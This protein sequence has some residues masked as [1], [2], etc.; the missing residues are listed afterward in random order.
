MVKK[1]GVLVSVSAFAAVLIIIFTNL[2]PAQPD[3]KSS[4]NSSA[5]EN[6]WHNL[7]HE[8]EQF[9]HQAN[10]S[11]HDR[12]VEIKCF[13]KM[14]NH[15]AIEIIMFHFV[16][17]AENDTSQIN[18]E[19]LEK[20]K[21]LIKEI[22]ENYNNCTRDVHLELR[23]HAKEPHDHSESS[24]STVG[25]TRNEKSLNETL[26]QVT[27]DAELTTETNEEIKS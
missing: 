2:S 11:H 10:K 20:C 26:T 24:N 6:N 13:K 25:I 5:S 23:I 22:K 3:S 17:I 21:Y 18:D 4:S 7:K 8:Y 12:L 14:L 1:A 9:V 19:N 16:K 15:S 27:K